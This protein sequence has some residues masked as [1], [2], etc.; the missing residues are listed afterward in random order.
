MPRTRFH[1][2]TSITHFCYLL[3]YDAGSVGVLL[4][5]GDMLPSAWFA[6]EICGHSLL[7]NATG[8]DLPLFGNCTLAFICCSS[9][10]AWR[11]PCYCN[12]RRARP[13]ILQAT[14]L[15]LAARYRTDAPTNGRLRA[16]RDVRHLS[17][18]CWRSFF[19]VDTRGAERLPG[20]SKYAITGVRALVMN[21][22]SA[23]AGC[24]D[25]AALRLCGQATW[26]S[27]LLGGSGCWEDPC[28][29][30]TRPCPPPPLPTHHTFP[31]PHPAPCAAACS[32]W[33]RTYAERQVL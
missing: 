29:S 22:C 18:S 9:S 17:R 10:A 2:V 26:V 27:V 5:S 14:L 31:F 19:D 20:S 13:C 16:A 1:A 32:R 15:M 7:P 28:P 33:R 23:L 3:L 8:C 12:N 25:D 21:L 11:V 6:T 30:P 24:A 4:P